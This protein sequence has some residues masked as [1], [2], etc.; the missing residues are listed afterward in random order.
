[1]VEQPPRRKAIRFR[2]LLSKLDET[3]P[4]EDDYP[5]QLMKVRFLPS[6]PNKKA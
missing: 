3:Q 6:A 4:I 5:K 2:N 1:M